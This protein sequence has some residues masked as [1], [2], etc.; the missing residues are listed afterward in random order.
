MASN[1]LHSAQL[2][3]DGIHVIQAYEYAN[4]TARTTATGFVTADIGKVARQTDN[5]TFWILIA[6]TP[7]WLQI[8]SGA[9]PT[10]HASTH[11]HGGGDEVATA[12]PGANAIP[13]ADGAGKLDTWIS[14]S[15]E[16]VKGKIEIATQ[17][18]VD[19]GTDTTKA[20]TPATLASIGALRLQVRNESGSLIPAGSLVAPV[21]YSGGLILVDLADKDNPALRPAIAVADVAIPDLSN[22]TV[23]RGGV[24]KGINTS[25]YSLT[26]QLVLGTAGSFSRSPPDQDPFTGEVQN[27]GSVIRID[28][29]NG[30]VSVDLDGLSPLTAD[31]VFGLPITMGRGLLNGGALTRPGGLDIDISAGEGYVDMSGTYV[32]VLWGAQTITL[33]AS[34]TSHVYIDSTGTAQSTTSAP[35]RSQLDDWIVLGTAVTTGSVTAILSEHRVLVD[36]RNALY[37]QRAE[38][39]VGPIAVS[40]GIVTENA[41]TPLHLDVTAA[42][43]WI[44]DDRKST[45]AIVDGTF[46]AVYRDGVGGFTRLT[47]QTSVDNAQ[48]DDGTGTLAAIPSGEYAAHVVYLSPNVDGGAGSSDLVL[49]YPQATFTTQSEAEVAALSAP[50]DA[51]RNFSLRL[52]AVIIQEGN[53]NVVSVI[54]HRPFPQQLGP[55]VSGPS[56]HGNL[57][58]L[59]ADDHTQYQLRSEKGAANGYPDLDGSSL[60]PA[61]QLPSAT[62]LVKGAMPKEDKHWANHG[63]ATGWAE[64]GV[65]SQGAGLLDVDVSAGDGFVM[66]DPE[67][68]ATGTVDVDW[69]AATLTLGANTNNHIY[70]TAAGTVTSATSPP[71]IGD[72]IILGNAITNATDVAFISQ[73]MARLDDWL[74][75]SHLFAKDRVGSA[76]VTGCKGSINGATASRVDIASGTFYI[77]DNRMTTAGVAPITF[78]AWRDNGAGGFTADP[79]QTDVQ[80]KY[81]DGSGTLATIPSGKFA[82]H[83]FFICQNGDGDEFHMVYGK[84]LFNTVAQA[85][86]GD[87]P[88]PPPLVVA[89]AARFA[90][91]I[92]GNGSTITEIVDERLVIGQNSNRSRAGQVVRSLNFPAITSSSL[93]TKGEHLVVS[94]AANG[95][96][97]FRFAIPRDFLEVVSI[98]MRGIPSAAAAGSGKSITLDSNYASAGEVYNLHAASD[99]R[100]YNL[101]GTADILSEVIDLT[102]VFGSIAA[103]DTCGVKVKHNAI[104][105]SVEYTGIELVYVGAA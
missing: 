81:D 88:T 66:V 16:T 51:L 97:N 69:N 40:G 101:T 15:S 59:G 46:V 38:E 56:V 62:H 74:K 95:S 26:D 48:Y 54:D 18:E 105:G 30:E 34:S 70:V 64:G 44:T 98:R 52:A 80:N 60:V 93:Q 47:G 55:S 41:G 82:K 57:L 43:F 67:N 17:A 5:E 94:V 19:A 53:S 103:G 6:P 71:D 39:T 91:A 100:N 89:F 11:Q 42:N 84:T 37:H 35:T 102:V 58:G 3:A 90:A 12:T 75:S 32:R 87:N 14:D 83:L 45:N 68:P 4:A 73:H 63:F 20:I 86:V 27:V 8:D 9:A 24:L 85:R 99:T 13:K 78:S 61:A 7:T 22:G 79:H 77:A 29:V 49:V 96:S 1:P 25:G 72:N 50:S 2:P 104:G 23:L 76:V 28:A 65:L 36:E 10:A 33:P 21:G 92:Q 31:Q